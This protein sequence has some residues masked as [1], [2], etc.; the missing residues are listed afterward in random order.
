MNTE[1]TSV[2]T[3]G[4][5][6]KEGLLN[7][8]KRAD[9]QLNEFAVILLES[10]HCGITP[11]K[12]SLTI[13]EVT[14]ESLGL[15]QGGTLSEIS[16]GARRKGLGACSLEAAFYIRLTYPDPEEIK[17]S[18]KTP[19]QNPPG[20]L[21][22]YTEALEQDDT[23]PRGLYLRKIEGKSWLRGYR[24]SEDYLWAPSDR[25]LFRVDEALV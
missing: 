14:V 9:I 1:A 13:E 12:H 7:E 20:A 3:Y 6:S 24:C 4:G 18:V 16:E 21:V 22:I 8:L 23:F 17:V 10:P 11:I 5:L 19:N 2:V 25:F 15:P